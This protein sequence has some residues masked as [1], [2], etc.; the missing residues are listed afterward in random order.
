[1]SHVITCKVQIKN[2]AALERAAKRCGLEMRRGQKHYRWFGKFVGDSPMPAGFTESQLGKCDHALGIPGNSSAYEVGV[3]ARAGGQ[4]ELI[5]DYW[6]GG[7]GLVD[8]IGK[9]AQTLKDEYSIAVAEEKCAEL[10]WYCERV[11]DELQ[12]FVPGQQGVIHVTKDQVDA[13][14]FTGPGCLEATRP[15]A[16]ALGVELQDQMKPEVGIVNQA[17]RVLS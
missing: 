7:Y 1:M 4:Y 2:L 15:I 3:V 9:D 6:S 13:V 10:G 14:G 16:E 17:N 8:K 12:I 11:G 5:W